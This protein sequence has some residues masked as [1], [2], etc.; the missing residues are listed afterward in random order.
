MR[1]VL[2]RLRHAALLFL[3]ILA[4]RY[5]TALRFAVW[6]GAIRPIAGADDDPATL[7]TANETLK[8]DYGPGFRDAINKANPAWSLINRD[9]RKTGGRHVRWTVR[10]SLSP[11]TGWRGEEEATPEAGHTEHAEA[12]ENVK[13]FYHIFR[14]SG[15]SMDLS[16]GDAFS[17]MS[18][19]EQEMKSGRDA[20]LRD[21]SRVSLLNT[22]TDGTLGTVGAA[23]AAST[24]I[25]LES[26]TEIARMLFFFKNLRIDI[27]DSAGVFQATRIVSDADIDA[28][29]VT[30]TEAVDTSIG[31]TLHRQGSK[32]KEPPGLPGIIDNTGVLHGIDPATEPLWKSVVVG[33]GTKT[34]AEELVEELYDEMATRGLGNEPEL[35]TW[36]HRQRRKLAAQLQRQKRY[37]GRQVTL[38]AGWKGLEVARGVAVADR[39]HLDD[40]IFA[41]ETEELARFQGRPFDWDTRFGFGNVL[42]SVE[43]ADSFRARWK[44]YATLGAYTRPAHGRLKVASV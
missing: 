16:E 11:G 36:S 9:W 42:R 39:F 44:G 33:D 19:L 8:E 34:I 14:I 4:S 15:P 27:F 32:G 13:F 2:R 41:I 7:T 43:G 26:T 23:G 12:T 22:S 20:F 10:T 6:T 5:R 21:V 31:D 29:T 25:T 24:T 3:A 38:R 35:L 30:V 1:K 40:D 18:T 37:D 28:R 17:F